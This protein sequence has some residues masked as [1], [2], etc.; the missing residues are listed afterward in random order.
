[1]L[2]EETGDLGIDLIYLF[3]ILCLRR[4]EGG[5]RGAGSFHLRQS[6]AFIPPGLRQGGGQAV[7]NILL[8]VGGNSDA[9]RE[10]VLPLQV[11]RIE[12]RGN[13][14]RPRLHPGCKKF[15]IRNAGSVILIRQSG[16]G[17]PHL[18]DQQK[19]APFIIGGKGSIGIIDASAAITSAVDHDQQRVVG[20]LAGDITQGLVVF[21]QQIAFGIQGIEGGVQH[22]IFVAPLARLIG[23]AFLRGTEDGADIKAFALAFVGLP[24]KDQVAVTPG[25]F[26]EFFLLIFGVALAQQQ[27]VD[28]LM[29]RAALQ[30]AVDPVIAPRRFADDVIIRRIDHPTVHRMAQ[31]LPVADLQHKA[32]RLFRKRRQHALMKGAHHPL[33]GRGGGAVFLAVAV[34]A[35]TEDH[36]VG[37]DVDQQRPVGAQVVGLHQMPGAAGPGALAVEL[38][39]G[40]DLRFLIGGM[41]II[42]P[43]GL[44]DKIIAEAQLILPKNCAHHYQYK[45]NWFHET[46]DLVF[47]NS[48]LYFFPD[49]LHS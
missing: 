35:L 11:I 33:P 13:V 9:R 39:Q 41:I 34:E 4:F 32:H 1:M 19:F 18:V 2:D 7:E 43:Q 45:K 14:D 42:D 36:P 44:V 28:L 15:L 8:P 40:E 3:L 17:M 20:H 49:S 5:F 37:G 21:R 27:Q 10:Q 22:G 31:V 46:S 26:G 48:F 25:V 16:E 23:A 47:I 6:G 29:C 24:L 30:Q 38:I 12:Q